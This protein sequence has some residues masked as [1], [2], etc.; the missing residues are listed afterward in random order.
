MSDVPPLLLDWLASQPSH[1]TVAWDRDVPAEHRWTTD[2]DECECGNGD[3]TGPRVYVDNT[4]RPFVTDGHGTS[5]VWTRD[6]HDPLCG[7]WIINSRTDLGY[8]IVGRMG[9]TRSLRP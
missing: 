6:I 4:E 5:F 1:Y 9:E 3:H 7:S 2:Q 8:A